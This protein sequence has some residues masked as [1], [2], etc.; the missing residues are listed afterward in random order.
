MPEK[1]DTGSSVKPEDVSTSEGDLDSMLG[2]LDN[3]IEEHKDTEQSETEKICIG[4]ANQANEFMET[5]DAD[6]KTAH[7]SLVSMMQ[8]NQTLAS[9]LVEGLG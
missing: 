8:K 7:D 3:A 2:E 1:T 6:I 9:V 5:I 4:V